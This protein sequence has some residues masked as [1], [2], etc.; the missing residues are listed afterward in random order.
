MEG[1]IGDLGDLLVT[2]GLRLETDGDR[3]RVHHGDRAYPLGALGLEALDPSARRAELVAMAAGIDMAIKV[4]ATVDEVDFRTGAANLLPRIERAPFLRAY[5]GVSGG[6]DPLAHR[7]LGAGLVVV[8]VRDE[9]WRFRHVT[10]GQL[11][12][13][14]VDLRTLE[15]GARSNLY[16]RQ[17]PAWDQ[18]RI[19]VGDGYDAARLLLVEDVFFHLGGEEG[20][21]V[22]VPD[23]D[24]L[25]VGEGATAEATE[26]LYAAA[27]YPLSPRPW[28][29]RRGGLLPAGAP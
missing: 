8:F 7:D 5:H 13:W 29:W 15:Q 27:Q 18:T 6:E 21:S 1:L 11:A 24:H 28:R 22:S 14:D 20:I 16:H 17:A 4:P 25:L 19:S 3:V 23:A 12:H 26:E 2:V 9:G 10:L